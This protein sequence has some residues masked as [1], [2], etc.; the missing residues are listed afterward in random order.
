MN[1]KIP[2]LDPSWPDCMLCSDTGLSDK[3]GEWRFCGCPAGKELRDADPHAADRAQENL[4]R[5]IQKCG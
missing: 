5:L 4:N 1:H 2:E 3:T